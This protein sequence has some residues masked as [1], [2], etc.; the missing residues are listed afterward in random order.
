MFFT[1]RNV[2]GVTMQRACQKAPPCP[3]LARL[4][5]MQKDGVSSQLFQFAIL[6][7][8]LWLG[9]KMLRKKWVWRDQKAKKNRRPECFNNDPQVLRV[10]SAPDTGGFCLNPCTRL[11]AGYI[12][13]VEM[14]FRDIE[15]L[16]H[17]L[18]VSRHKSGRTGLKSSWLQLWALRN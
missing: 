3:S 12:V 7:G 18:P 16:V 10:P 14:R 11:G 5:Q 17:F 1:N 15:Q 6:K 9:W 2:V 13:H 4:E 8:P